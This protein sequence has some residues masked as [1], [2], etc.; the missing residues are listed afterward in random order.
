MTP[1]SLEKQPL[2]QWK[3]FFKTVLGTVL[4]AFSNWRNI[5]ENR[6][7][8]SKNSGGL[9]NLSPLS[10]QPWV[11]RSQA[12]WSGK[13]QPRSQGSSPHLQSSYAFTLKGIGDWCFSGFQNSREEWLKRWGSNLVEQNS[14][15]GTMGWQSWSLSRPY[16]N[17]FIRR[18]STPEGQAQKT[19]GSHPNPS[20]LR[21]EVYHSRR[22]RPECEQ[23]KQSNQKTQA[24]KLAFKKQDSVICCGQH[25][26]MATIC[27][28]I[29]D[30]HHHVPSAATG[31]G[32]GF[33]HWD[34][35]KVSS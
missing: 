23:I 22:S 13:V 20:L 17:S 21:Q 14:T 33:S 18:G 7:R 9:G 1:F 8:L 3:L 2:N 28:I 19:R 35:E 34:Q 5:W 24:A 6:L 30:L 15:P 4:R 26:V 27:I 32:E 12:L 16:T 25:P 29:T 11:T 10:P 31:P